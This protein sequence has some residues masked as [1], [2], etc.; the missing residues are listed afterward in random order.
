MDTKTQL[1]EIVE[2]DVETSEKV[3]EEYSRDTS[4]F[5]VKPDI[6]VFPKNAEDVK[7]IITYVNEH[8]KENPN[9]SITGRSAGTDM[10]GGPLNESIILSFTRYMNHA[11]VH[12][13]EDWALVE[14]G[15]YYRD[16][17]K[18]TIPYHVYVPSYPASKSICALGGMVMNNSG[19]E[20]TLRY[21]QTR[22]FVDEITMVLS[23]GNEY[24]FRNLT[25]EELEEQMAQ[26]NFW[27]EIHRKMYNLLEENFDLIHKSKPITSKN[28][29]GYALWDV[30]DR[31]E[32]RLPQLFTGSQGTLGIMSSAKL[33]LM[34]DKPCKKLVVLFFKDWNQLPDIVNAIL[35]IGPESLEAF[36]DETLKLGLRFMPEIAKKAGSNLISFALRFLPEVL[37]GIKM[38]GIPKLVI[39]VHLVEDSQKE[40]QN[41]VDNLKTVLKDFHVLYR[42][43]EDEKEA[44]KYWIMRRESFALLRKHVSGKKTAPFVDDFCVVPGKVPEFLP[45]MLKILKDHGI[46][47]NIA[48]HAGSG[49]FHIIPLM[50]LQ[51]PEERH[52][53]PIVADKIYDLI[54]QYKGTITAEHN[55]GIIRTPYLE[56]MYGKEMY[57]LFKEVKHVFDPQNI[58]NPGKKVGGSLSY[59]REHIAP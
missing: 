9:L 48:G 2:G 40:L 57:D 38:L 22:K 10:S 30:W 39:M 13:T 19:G 36:D 55:D 31:K 6:V 7:R 56:K 28:S 54:I 47:A 26:Q 59:M 42:E 18:M 14:P 4:L 45:K 23:D 27:G 5:K 20:Q 41:K 33:K 12:P 1:E 29:A 21:G 17:E 8:K 44:E 52:K 58:F 35:P 37:I 46:K 16:F 24:T 34:H 3:L 50:N 51:D 53:I 25:K 15:I 43:T 49:N 32:F 11:E